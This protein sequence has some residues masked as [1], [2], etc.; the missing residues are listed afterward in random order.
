MSR[1]PLRALGGALA[2]LPAAAALYVAARVA[3]RWATEPEAG[4]EEEEEDDDD[5]EEDEG[6]ELLEAE[7]AGDI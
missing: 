1:S 6:D 7:G 3:Y 4:G 5:E 2:A